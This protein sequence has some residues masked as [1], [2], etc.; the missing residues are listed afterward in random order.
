MPYLKLSKAT[1]N[2]KSIY[3]TNLHVSYLP[4]RAKI[5]LEITIYYKINSHYPLT[6]SSQ[7]VGYVAPKVLCYVLHNSDFNILSIAEIQ[8]Q[9]DYVLDN[10]LA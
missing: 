9:Q 4:N 7:H 5:F 6:K 2:N 8:I 1:T 10:N 3:N